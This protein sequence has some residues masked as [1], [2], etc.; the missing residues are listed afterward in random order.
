[1][2][3]QGLKR[4]QF[5]GTCVGQTWNEC[6]NV[7]IEEAV[8]QMRDRAFTCIDNEPDDD[9]LLV[10]LEQENRRSE[11][12][13]L[14]NF[15]ST[16]AGIDTACANL[17]A[18]LRLVKRRKCSF[19]ARLGLLIGAVR[20]ALNNAVIHGNRGRADAEFTVHAF[21]SDSGDLTV[22]VG[23]DA[24][25]G[26]QGPHF[27]FSLYEPPE[28]PLRDGGRGIPL[29]KSFADSVRVVPGE[30]ELVFTCDKEAH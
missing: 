24:E 4:P 18:F 27:D 9:F 5:C 10:A 1:M 8:R 6:H 16:A 20:E 17:E 26:R 28:N 12:S 19:D 13:L 11:G 2:D 3:R 7:T 23:D 21:C 30:V 14:Q 29:M 22:R 25:E 15:P